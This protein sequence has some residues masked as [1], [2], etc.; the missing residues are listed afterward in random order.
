MR[1]SLLLLEHDFGK[2]NTECC[3]ALSHFFVSPNHHEAR[4]STCIDGSMHSPQPTAAMTASVASIPGAIGSLK[5]G[6]Y[7]K[8]KADGKASRSR[9]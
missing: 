5:A 7:G 9:A 4:A 3:P 8:V 1:L 6:I 2:F